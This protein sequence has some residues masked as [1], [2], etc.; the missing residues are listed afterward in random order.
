MIILNNNIMADSTQLNIPI[1]LNQA[2]IIRKAPEK[3]A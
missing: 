1:A 2:D 3:F